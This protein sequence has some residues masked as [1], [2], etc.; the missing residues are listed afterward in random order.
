MSA[1]LANSYHEDLLDLIEPLFIDHFKHIHGSSPSIMEL[2]Q[3][4]VSTNI[5]KLI[6]H[7]KSINNRISE[8]YSHTE[9][10]RSINIYIRKLR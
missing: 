6:D 2:K 1:S 7:I 10:T 4:L 3:H 8:I 9:L 5:E